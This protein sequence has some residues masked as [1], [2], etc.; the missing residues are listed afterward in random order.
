MR[1]MTMHLW[2]VVSARTEVYRKSSQTAQLRGIY[3]TQSLLST[4]PSGQRPDQV[5]P[6]VGTVPPSLANDITKD[7]MPLAIAA[8]KAQRRAKDIA[9]NNTNNEILSIARK[10]I[11]PWFRPKVPGA[12]DTIT[13]D[14]RLTPKKTSATQAM[15]AELNTEIA[16]TNLDRILYTALK[17]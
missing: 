4:D 2:L 11:A 9:G 5:P 1:P 10:A 12:G 8:K 7:A 14:D 15:F 6:R 13:E 3:R 16:E 17:V